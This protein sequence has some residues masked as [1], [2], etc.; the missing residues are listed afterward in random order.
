MFPLFTA[1]EEYSTGDYSASFITSQVESTPLTLLRLFDVSATL[2]AIWELLSQSVSLPLQWR[3]LGRNTMHDTCWS[4]LWT[5]TCH[6]HVRKEMFPATG[7]LQT[8][9]NIFASWEDLIMMTFFCAIV[10]LKNT[11][12]NTTYS[13]KDVFIHIFLSQSWKFKHYGQLVI[14]ASADVSKIRKDIL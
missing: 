13:L 2:H 8:L 3:I 11:L 5:L 12:H 10:S 1:P 14:G 9:K 6:S 4:L 7:L